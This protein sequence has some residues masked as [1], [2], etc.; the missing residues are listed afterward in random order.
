MVGKADMLLA[1]R[2]LS[3]LIVVC[4]LVSGLVGLFFA[5]GLT[6][7][8]AASGNLVVTGTYTIENIVQPVDGNVY[9]NAGGNLIVRNATLSILSNGNP[10]ERHSI[11]INSSGTLTLDHGTI[12]T[13]L[14]QIDPWPFLTINVNGGTI[15]ASGAS[16]LQFPGS[17]VLTGA[18]SV[19]L[20]DSTIT[21]LPSSLVSDFVVG[22]GGSLTLDQADD[23]PTISLADLSWMRLY[24]SSILKLPEYATASM[25]AANIT[26]SGDA[27]LL[28]VN[29]YI[30]VDFGPIVNPT[31]W[32]VHNVMV[33]NGLARAYLYG[34]TFETYA[35]ANADRA[36]AIVSSVSGSAAYIYRWLNASVGDEY[37]VPIVDAT[38]SATFTG[39]TDL[40]GQTA[41][42]YTYSGVSTTPPAEV[43]S[44]L[45]ETAP[46]Y[47]VTKADGRA[48]IPYLTDI[49]ANGMADS[50]L[51]VGSYEFTGSKTIDG[52]PYSST[53]AF[54]LKAY[55]AMGP[56]DKSSDFTVKLMGVSV[57][58]P[59]SSRWLVVP[60]SLVIEGMTY[61][62]AGDVIVAANGTLDFENAV[63]QLV[64][65]YSNQRSILVDG[66]QALPGRLEFHNT[67]VTSDKIIN[68]IVQGYGIVEA[69]DTEF[70]GV[71]IIAL[72][73]SQVIFHNVTMNGN[74][75]TAWDS[76]AQINVYDSALLQTITLSGNAVGGFTNTSVPSVHVENDAVAYIYRWIHVTVYDGAGYPCP[77]ATVTARYFID[78]DVAAT[79][80]ADSQGVA[81]VR[82]IGTIISSTGSTF[83]GN[84]RVNASLSIHSQVYYADNEISVG[85]MP[86]T[87]PL[88]KN[89]TYAAMSIPGALPDLTSVVVTASPSSPRNHASTYL[90]AT[91]FNTGAVPAHNI[92]ADFYDTTEAGTVFIGTG[93][94]DYVPVDGSGVISLIWTA[95][96]PLA[97]K[98][99][100]ITA[101]VD[102]LNVVKELD[103]TPVS[104]S[105]S[106]MVQNLMDVYVQSTSTDIWTVPEDIVV[107]TGV[108]LRANVYNQGDATT[109]DILVEFWDEPLGTPKTY[110][111][112]ATVTGIQ[113]NTL[114]VATVTW[115]PDVAGSHTIH[116]AVNGGIA[117]PH[118]DLN[119]TT[120]AN[121]EASRVVTVLTPP[122]L[123]LSNI[124]FDPIGSVP[125]G[126]MLTISATLR[127]TQLA[128]VTLTNISLYDQDPT[129]GSP[130]AINGYLVTDRLADNSAVT[131]SFTF[132]A[133]NVEVTTV[134]TYYLVV[135][136]SHAQPEEL[137]YDDNMVFGSIT[138]LDM[139]PDLV[140]T[141]SS[142]TVYSGTQDITSSMFGRTVRVEVN[143]TNSGGR[144]AYDFSIRVGIRNQSFEGGGS[145]NHTFIDQ[146]FNISAPPDVNTVSA[147]FEWKIVLTIPADYQIWAFVDPW[148]NVSEPSE[149]NNW[150][151]TPF[152]IVPLAADVQIITEKTEYT[153]GDEVYITATITYQGTGV[154]VP[155]VPLV[156]FRLLDGSGNPVERSDTVAVNSSEGGVVIQTLTVP[157]DIASGS[158]EVVAVFFGTTYYSSTAANLQI[159]AQVSGGLFPWWV[160]IVIIV[161]VGAAIAGFT[162]Y[163]YFY[164]LGKYVECGE[165][166]AFIPA[167]SKR[168][169]KCG[170]EFEAGTMK[171]SECGAWIPAESTECPNCGVK[172]VGEAEEEG[173][174][175]ER[176][177]KEYDE[178]VSK[179]RELARPELGKKFSD[180]A[181]DD[182]WKRQPGYITFDD[183]LAKEEEKK[184]EGPVPCPVC[185]TLNP[186]EATVCH[187]CGTVFGVQ[188]EG[189]P[190]RGPPPAA[191]PSA[192]P[193]R[194]VE[195]AA[196]APPVQEAAPGAAPR[197][198]IR[199]PIEKKVVPK[200]IIRSPSGQAV[201]EEQKE[202]NNQ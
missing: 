39:S 122:N 68:I 171:C 42:Y 133:P 67:L 79:G 37:G 9:V 28:A 113:W 57:E 195:R 99:H 192:A 44:Y 157:T 189:P 35:G 77:G 108:L 151:V 12:T 53:A 90:N 188:K 26:L 103:E 106:L 21:G 55:P 27:N 76:N 49:I 126:D 202:D 150:A 75:T 163:T 167:A 1:N 140:V 52:T 73:D 145:Y 155:D 166:G 190:G 40:E 82:S 72:E 139:R 88:G 199:R 124:Q 20:T 17:I 191:P 136:P 177:K 181:F 80:T 118:L 137:S 85:V 114:K 45:G 179:Y 141:P 121:N 91:V 112:N 23:G 201:E 71:N 134:V 25:P 173:D 178:M 78:G 158:Y 19:T 130:T 18:A 156:I 172:F 83:V 148:G 36:P 128:P 154:A 38:I 63:F 98:T 162:V 4:L 46:T 56:G 47:Q 127:N 54:S 164:G 14:D 30:A 87:E 135:N 93:T 51:Y 159:S 62:H 186:K 74:I 86:Y 115:T 200:K 92:S 66:T 32:Y 193:P 95:L 125:G 187:K 61:Y 41:F 58:S 8:K 174:Y 33:L 119:E 59:N 13:Y 184:K 105:T 3:A 43:L 89:A 152:T 142:I 48:V 132:A 176:M 160:W 146:S 138:V 161:I 24:D 97:P 16:L 120:F 183:W 197:M 168:C 10:A 194:E 169:P 102:P 149:T 198:V 22:A 170:V 64:Q 6:P 2:T 81:R 100:T 104:G 182:W 65:E 60:P 144:P 180:K 175:L 96:P 5:V 129:V 109:G 110:I 123:V 107:N 34:C 131:V 11:T 94:V 70:Q 69:W 15:V 101:Y 165:C 84:Y 111:G 29:S 153:A 185:G 147:S 143:V 7:V 117:G 31:D 196:E 116:V 50:P